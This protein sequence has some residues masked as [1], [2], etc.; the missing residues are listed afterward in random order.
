M[1]DA[2][3]AQFSAPASCPAN[4]A[5]L[6]LRGYRPNGSLDGIVVDVDAT[7]SQENTKPIPVFGDIGESLSER[8]LAS[9]AGT[10]MV[11]PGSHG[12]DQWR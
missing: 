4:R 9:D 11:E 1:S 10:M 6:R 8:R 12:C 7:I 3:V 2:I 5:F